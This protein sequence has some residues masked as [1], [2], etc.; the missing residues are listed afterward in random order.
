MSQSPLPKVQSLQG[1]KP[2]HMRKAASQTRGRL[3]KMCFGVLCAGALIAAVAMIA[4]VFIT[5]PPPNV[6][7]GASHADPDSVGAIVLR[8]GPSGCQQKSYDDRTGHFSDQPSSCHNDVVLDALGIPVPAGTI[9]TLNSISKSFKER[10]T[11]DFRAG[12]AGS[13]SPTGYQRSSR[14]HSTYYLVRN[15]GSGISFPTNG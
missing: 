6:E 11:P 14:A 1:T 8:S 2:A 12:V 7:S 4:M 5:V 13:Y 3:A 15:D 10:Y 9:H